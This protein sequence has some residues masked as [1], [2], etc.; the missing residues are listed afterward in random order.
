MRMNFTSFSLK[1]AV[2]IIYLLLCVMPS[3]AQQ[4]SFPGAEGAGRFTSGGRGTTAVTTTVFEVTNLNDDNNPGSLR[5]ALS[6]TAT[7]R[8]VVFR[9]SGTIHLISKL[10]IRSNTTVAG[11]T[12]PGDGICI[13][14][15]PT[16]ISGD[17]V[18]V[19][20]MRFRMGD[21]NTLLTSPAGCG[22]PVAPFTAAC[23]PLDGSGGDDSF[24]NL[25]GKNIIIDHCTSS[26]S[27]DEALT[28]YRGDSVT[29][30]WN[31]IS[32]PLNYSYHF[33]TGD[34]DFEHHG[35]GGIWGSKHGSFH[36]NLI[37]DAKGRSPRFSGIS[38]YSP[39]TVG[40]E[41]ADFR[42]NIIYNW[43]SYSSNG[44]EGGNYNVVNNYYKYGPSTG[45]GNSVSIPIKGMIVQPAQTTS[46]TII[47]YGKF[48]VAG[49]Y[50]DGY[51]S[52]TTN[53]WLGVSMSG[54]TQA[55]TTL[56]KATTPFDIA[57]VTTHTASEAYDLVLQYAGASLKRDTLDERITNDVRNR[58]GKQ[59]DVQGDF[60]H[61]TAYASTV[62]AW[63]TL[64]STTA[65]TDTD[66]DGMPDAW[67]TANGLNPNDATDRGLFATSG[68]TNLENYLNSLVGNPAITSSVSSLSQFSQVAGIPSAVQIYSISAA[69]LTA[70]V[71]VTPPAG[72]QISAD[73][74]T[75]WFTNASPLTL[76][77]A[78]GT[79]TPKTISVRLNVA[80][81]GSYNGN[82]THTSTNAAT[83]NV[84]VTGNTISSDAP[85]G[86]NAVVALDG[87]GNYT[88]IQAAINAAPTGL[89]TP[90]II[91]I[92]NGKYVEKVNIPS[93]KP[94]IQL[95]GQSAA[96]T[97]ISWADNGI[98]VGTFSSYTV[99][100]AANDC[101]LMNLT[102]A[103]S[104][105]DG[106]QAVALR[107][108]GDRIIIRSCRIMGNQDTLLTAGTS[109][110]RQLFKN[111]YI[112]G[113]VDFIFGSARAI[114]DSTVI[115]AKDRGTAGN[116]YITAPNT[117]A[118]QT[119]GY[120]FR[121]CILPPN[122]G[123]TNYFL[124]RPWQN[125]TGSNP[126]ANN[127]TVF[128]NSTMSSSILPAGWSIWDAGTNTSLIYFGEYK[129]K[130]FDGSLV[131]VSSRVPWSYQ[132]SDAD[133]ATYTDTD[134]FGSWDPC[135]AG[136][137]FCTAKSPE[138]AI[139]NFKGKK[140][141]DV[142]TFN[143]N[144]SWA[145]PQIKYE[146]YR[147]TVK[148]SGYSKVA[149]L[150]SLEDT[151]YNFQLTDVLPPSGTIYYYY[152][153][154][155]KT[156][157]ISNITDTIFISNVPTVTTTGTL[158]AFAQNYGAPSG[159]QIAVTSG[160]NLTGNI[161]VTP[162]A[163]YE[164]STNGSTW[165]TSASP[166]VLTPSAGVL[167]N[168]NVM[169]RLNST[170]L[171]A[172]S[173]N[174]AF[175]SAGA[176]TVNIAVTGNCSIIPQPTT[177]L[178]Q[179]YPLTQG[180][181]DSTAVRNAGVA[182][183]APT[184]N[185]F[186]LSDGVTV[187]AVPAYS[188]TYGQ[189]FAATAT[190]FWTTASG[191]PGGNLNRIFYEQFTV[192]SNTG[193]NV[194]VDSLTFLSAFYGSSSNTK[195]AV[196]YSRSGFVSDSTDISTVPGTFTS[197]I[198]LTNQTSGTTAAYAIAFNASNSIALAPGQTLTFRLYFSC[199]S[200]SSGRYGMLKDV[201]V[202]GKSVSTTAPTPTV[203]TTGNTLTAFTQ[204]IG[205]PSAVQTYTVSGTGLNGAVYVIAPT[206][207]E[208]SNDA[209]AS[210]KNSTQPIILNPTSGALAATTI[211]VRLNAGVAG[212]N[213]G[214]IQHLSAG[215]TTVNVAVTGTTL[216]A[217]AIT[218]TGSLTAFSHIIGSTSATQT[219]NVSAIGL[220]TDLT[221]TPPAGFEVSVNGTNWFTNSSPLTITPTA[222]IINSTVQVRLNGS[223]I[224][225]YSGTINHTSTGAIAKTIAETGTVLAVPGLFATSS[226]VQFVQTL[227]AASASQSFTL[228]GNNLLNNITVT[229]PLRYELSVNGGSTW[230]SGSVTVSP[231]SGSLNQTILVRLNSPLWGDYNGNIVCASGT[232]TPVN[233]AVTGYATIEKKHTL[234]PNPVYK[235]IYYS[236]PVSTEQ[237]MINIYTMSG[238]KI[239]KLTVVPG[240][241][242]TTIDVENL[243][244][245]VYSAEY[246]NRNE[247]VRIRFVKFN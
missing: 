76:T 242:I 194:Q 176:T 4:I 23:M 214:N 201:K 124:A 57:P 51:T 84:A 198:I 191:G 190:G 148:T 122:L 155:S 173:G 126:Y 207:Y 104:Y 93:N 41:N 80:T 28:V 241:Y 66:H 136:A 83:V 233:I 203:T 114:F 111:C 133:A 234:F 36:H 10:N 67:E 21:K 237:G 70:N 3:I 63:P 247:I 232:F 225:A 149:E 105:G 174:V 208:I 137:A 143:W 164:V 62:N 220:T 162:P 110:N 18:I 156:G 183:S 78:S 238:I 157:L 177:V 168:T 205:S 222:G 109:G 86:T 13:A 29:L 112:D 2:A 87:S 165:Y 229:P 39:A 163:P 92:K 102:I 243:K 216:T 212:T 121:N 244:Q 228:T 217:P 5:Y 182:A 128:L 19:R 158:A 161:T 58:T 90:Y 42:N 33:E 146:L 211:S 54:G 14:D 142:S 144:I 218:I 209:G 8:T 47:P 185:K 107:T 195:V 37:A 197:P 189:A 180:A 152:L 141:T 85:P 118:G 71:T 81:A 88:S 45:T 52:I 125:S 35:Y 196:V 82:I 226:M 119:Y 181:N 139:S 48:Y 239:K 135:T 206:N 27:S 79:V 30:Q 171:G 56:A 138:I 130:K 106:S 60:P 103:N 245:G 73:G 101:A 38:T 65:P 204:L 200:T 159:S 178:L 55:D 20:Y 170:S 240:S 187:P 116:S 77:P 230:T 26:W 89:T 16:A 213:N 188:S 74:G 160:A 150:T 115:Y 120:V 96:N 179:Q 72:Y 224:A 59:I 192:T 140:G 22:V 43:G 91:Y 131:N 153:V 154:G 145:M 31:I 15:Y 172:Y 49:N 25:G 223:A 186:V 95:I 7:H 151:T 61:G 246:I 202:I 175:T 235:V 75:T 40:I 227:P 132:L 34:N 108:D 50:V 53:N 100:V 167:A 24:G 219:Y 166:L 123:V 215:I 221:V 184:F 46:G 64:N 169:I 11:Q 98:N 69:N 117:Q 12:A 97:I 147:S 127:K 1:P 9:V 44:G 32:E 231:S 6:Q 134:L 129:S 17:N 94:F 68:Y 113:N 199:G 193:Y 210:W 99:Y 236:H